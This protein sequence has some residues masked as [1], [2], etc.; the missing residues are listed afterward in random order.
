MD[1]GGVDQL[2]FCRISITFCQLASLPH[3]PGTTRPSSRDAAAASHA[4]LASEQ[5][6]P[7][8]T[9]SANAVP[10]KAAPASEDVFITQRGEKM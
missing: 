6:V 10:G 5:A 3:P 1:C 2:L 9:A 7:A 8:I 4:M